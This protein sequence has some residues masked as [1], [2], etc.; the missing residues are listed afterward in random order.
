M[1]S[2]ACIFSKDYSS[3]SLGDICED[4]DYEIAGIDVPVDEHGFFDG[5]VRITI[6]YFPERK[7]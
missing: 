7:I 1:K 3:E 2:D 5:I 6:E 4:I